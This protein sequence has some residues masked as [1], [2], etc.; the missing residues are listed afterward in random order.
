MLVYRHARTIDPMI[1]YISEQRTRQI[2]G[3]RFG[4]GLA[5]MQADCDGQVDC[6]KLNNHDK[7][8]L[9]VFGS[10]MKV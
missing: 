9:N 7:L 8:S 3:M 5:L 10:A 2:L 1:V 4:R 6:E